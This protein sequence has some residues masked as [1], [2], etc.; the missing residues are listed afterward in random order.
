[1]LGKY[2]KD[3]HGKDGRYTT[4]GHEMGTETPLGQGNVDYP[5]FIKGLKDLGYDGPITIE[6]EITGDKQI[7]DIRM[8][9]EILEKLIAEA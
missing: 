6:R 2:F 3:V 7:E 5:R 4:N 9:K 1:M 8:A